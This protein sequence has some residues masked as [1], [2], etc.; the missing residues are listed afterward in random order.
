MLATALS[1]FALAAPEADAITKKKLDAPVTDEPADGARADF[2]ADRVTYDPRTETAVATGT[3]RITYGPYVLTATRVVYNRATDTFSANGS[4]QLREPNGN[5]LEATNFKL[6]NKFKDGFANHLRALLNNNVEITADYA[7]R[8]EGERTI[9]ER[10]TYTACG[11]CK[12][13][14]GVPLWQVVAERTEHDEESKTLY[15][16]KPV[17]EIG[18]VPVGG[19]PYLVM[20][21]PTVKRRTGFLPPQFK[22]GSRFGFGFILPYYWDVAPNA[23]LTFSPLITTKQG[24]VAD[25]E[26][27]HRLDSG[28]YNVRA[29]G[30]HEF[31]DELP[32]GPWR[33]G[34]ETQGRFTL[35]KDWRWG[36]DGLAATDKTFLRNYGF[37]FQKIGTNDVFVTGLW[38][39]TY[40]DARAITYSAL[41]A[42]VDWDAMPTVLPYVSGEHI[43]HD[44]VAG[45]QL[46]L[47]WSSY[48]LRRDEAGTPFDGVL[49]GTNQS[50]AVVDMRWKKQMISDL[51][52]VITPFARVRGD[53]YVNENVPDPLVVTNNQ[54]DNTVTRVLPAAGVDMRW[55]L[56]AKQF[57]G[58]GIVSPVMQ[59][60][61]ATDET[62]REKIGNEDAITVSFDHSSLFLDD[63]FTGLDRYEG[64]SRI[65]AGL[66]YSWFSD[67]GAFARASFGES[68]H[69]GGENSFGID[70]GLEGSKSD[71]V[72]A[73][74]AQPTSWL[75][76]AYETR[77]E[78][79]FSDF[80][81]HEASISL[82]F[83][84]ISGSVGYQFIDAE[85]ASGRVKA[86][87]YGFASGRVEVSDGWFVF[88]DANYDLRDD[89][90]RTAAVGI[91]FDCDCMNAKLSYRR[92]QSAK[93]VAEDNRVMF[94]IDLATLGGT[95]GSTGF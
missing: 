74:M 79:D 88:A 19:L 39:Q 38:D 85:P 59:V 3:V 41:D 34:A 90:M 29:Y 37:G 50:R 33:G 78:E 81:R 17:L 47:N 16:T 77:I 1:L 76:L 73:V 6:T 21:D 40:V 4:V 15:H 67:S 65:N 24:P 55:P 27:R 8:K 93:D 80:N 63:R 14:L 94:S 51:G 30:V 10:S 42:D 26:W 60:I 71:L 53:L 87:E 28:R 92:N 83:D 54:G 52:H 44:P 46:T 56:L 22:S 18:G 45:G 49:H 70:S 43:F 32:D 9:Y 23:D 89:F 36:W 61:A 72:A 75:N 66:T 7:V 95:S 20:P 64:G 2:D 69:I 48:S 82:S 11:G 58:Q 62:E 86:E 31:S 25:I 84:R 91:E 57:G 5:V 13:R 35:N 68:F 12:T